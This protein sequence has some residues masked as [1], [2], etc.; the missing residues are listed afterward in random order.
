MRIISSGLKAG[1]QVIV[2]GLQRVKPGQKVEPELIQA[3][4]PPTTVR[5]PVAAAPATESP[6]AENRP[7][8]PQPTAD[9]ANSQPRRTT[10]ER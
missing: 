7:A 1:E 9:P 5:K 4:L 3:T 8:L 2:K 6:P 10:Q